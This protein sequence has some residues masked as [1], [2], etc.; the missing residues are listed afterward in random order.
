M[1][2]FYRELAI[3]TATR[4]HG[5]RVC[6]RPADRSARH[7]WAGMRVHRTGRHAFDD[8]ADLDRFGVF[9]V[10]RL[11]KTLARLRQPLQGRPRP[12]TLRRVK[13]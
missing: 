7:Q 8:D 12:L 10:R 11:M 1:A 4:I 9:E 2:R 13:R 6:R 3:P 5:E